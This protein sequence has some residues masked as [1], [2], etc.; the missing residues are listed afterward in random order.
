[1][2]HIHSL[3]LF[4]CFSV[5]AAY[6]LAASIYFPYHNWDMIMY[7]AAAKSYE[8]KNIKSLHNFTYTALR[9]SVSESRYVN[10]VQHGY[11][12]AVHEDSSIFKEQ[13][14]FYQIRPIYTG[15]IYLLYKLGMNIGFAT[16]VISG[17]TVVIAL[18]L[19]FFM[20]ITF[21]KNSLAYSIPFFVLIFG[22]TDLAM[23]STP[24]GMAF[25]AVVL[26]AYLYLKQRIE[27]LLLLL[28]I[29]LGIRTDLVLFTL[30]LLFFIFATNKLF[31]KQ[32]A[33]SVIISVILYLFIN[34]YWSYPGWATIFYFTLIQNLTHPLSMPPTLT[35]SHYFF[36]LLNGMK[37]LPINSVFMLYVLISI[38]SFYIM[39]NYIKI[40][41][42]SNMFN[43]PAI[44]LSVVCI[45]FVCSHFLLFP[46]AWTRF[47][48][49]AYLIG[50]FSLLV[51]I[52]DY[53]KT[54]KLVQQ[55]TIH[56]L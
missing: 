21:L 2:K 13:L 56:E 32:A 36:A 49:G 46:V 51:M 54:L 22:A 42:L 55:D 27:L 9:Q 1:M 8:E 6:V 26:S 12:K 40:K 31:R 30:P 5:V 4:V 19:L 16:Y 11:R 24:D 53:V 52:I 33:I 28:P 47:F 45:I 17:V 44:V 50:T 43:S 35:I 23:C 34:T 7:I 20:S 15:T 37:G 3:M 41:S 48:S 39:V 38:S 14:P 10:M 18:L 29:I 25:L